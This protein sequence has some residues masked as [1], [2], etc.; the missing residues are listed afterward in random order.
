MFEAEQA[1][2]EGADYI[3]IGSAFPTRSKPGALPCGISVVEEVV[4]AVKVP[5]FAI[6]GINRDN[7]GE[8]V[9]VGCCRVAVISAVWDASDPETAAREIFSR[10]G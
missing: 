2:S 5:V 6:G 7:V 4:R 1:V 8:L 10:L 9:N 3:A